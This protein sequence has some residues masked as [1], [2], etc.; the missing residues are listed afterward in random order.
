ML[1]KEVVTAYFKDC[2]RGFLGIDAASLPPWISTRN[3]IPETITWTVLQSTAPVQNK[4]TE[5]TWNFYKVYF[6]ICYHKR[7]KFYIFICDLLQEKKQQVATS[8]QE[9]TID[10]HHLC[11]KPPHRMLQTT[12]MLAKEAWLT[13][14]H[15][16]FSWF[17]EAS[18]P[19]LQLFEEPT[20]WMEV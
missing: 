10:H 2:K 5:K 19:F 15:I 3:T 17:L 13:W 4:L 11:L 1:P 6:N 14:K 7:M 9:A 16:R 20:L 18:I 8:P 12:I